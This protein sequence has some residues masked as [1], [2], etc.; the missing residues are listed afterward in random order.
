MTDISNWLAQ[1][2]AASILIAFTFTQIIN[3]VV[4]TFKSVV[5]IKGGKFSAALL[6]GLSY[7][8]NAL[9]IKKITGISNET[10]LITLTFITNFVGV[11]AS[12]WIMDKIKKDKMWVITAIIPEK[13]AGNFENDLR[14]H[15]VT[16]SKLNYMGDTRSFMIISNS[17]GQSTLIGKIIKE[18]P[19]I[20]YTVSTNA[21][22]FR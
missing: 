12:L 15:L 7:A 9:V 22:K 17:K 13:Q 4:A 1:E 5:T 10:I 11:Y 2:G 3:V 16:F 18:Y 19:S 8:V 21:W 6:N 20:Q 14:L